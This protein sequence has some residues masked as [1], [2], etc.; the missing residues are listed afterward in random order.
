MDLSR[1]LDVTITTMSHFTA[2]TARKRAQG[3]TNMADALRFVD[4]AT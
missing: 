2:A 3:A 1:L 4:P